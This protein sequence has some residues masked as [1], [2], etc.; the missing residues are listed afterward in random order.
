MLNV[1]GISQVMEVKMTTYK[2][3]TQMYSSVGEHIGELKRV[4]LD[5]VSR[6]VS[7]LVVEKG[8]L[9]KEDKVVPIG[10]VSDQEG[11]RIA[12]ELTAEELEDFP[13]FSQTHFVL[14]KNWDKSVEDLKTYRYISSYHW[15]N[16]GGLGYATPRLMHKQ[17][18]NIPDNAVALKE[19]AN[20][21][22]P[23]GEKVGFLSSIIADSQSHAIT[24]VVVS[25]GGLNPVRKLVPIFWVDKFTGDKVDLLIQEK[26][27]Q[28]L[29]KYTVA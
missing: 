6:K 5:P 14:S 26:Y 28:N 11:N 17:L 10:L 12:L 20:V 1:L 24:H 23:N 25:N 16:A 13:Q 22:T 29:P 15:W 18:G 2:K 3:G 19:G 9:V 7:H 27:Y 21:V 8:I 4:V